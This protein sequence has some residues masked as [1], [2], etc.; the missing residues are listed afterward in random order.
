[1]PL[2]VQLPS[3]VDFRFPNCANQSRYTRKLPLYVVAIAISTV[4][5]L[6]LL[7]V[8]L[9]TAHHATS[10]H[11]LETP[12]K[13]LSPSLDPQPPTPETTATDAVPELMRTPCGVTK[14]SMLYGSHEFPQLQA[15]QEL[16]RK[17]SERWVCG[18]VGLDRDI[19][20]RKLYSK[21]YILLSTMLQE[22]AKPEESRQQW[23]L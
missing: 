12:V 18:W 21:H 10:E 7:S 13:H 9:P 1:M 14:V 3:H 17:H 11:G 4:S 8:A 19:S 20:S 23:L 22:L 16:H 6:W 2:Y 15:A 5:F